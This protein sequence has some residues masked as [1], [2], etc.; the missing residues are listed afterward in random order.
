M[1]GIKPRPH[2]GAIGNIVAAV[3][4]SE[5]LDSLETGQHESEKKPDVITDTVLSVVRSATNEVLAPQF[6]AL[7]MFGYGVSLYQKKPFLV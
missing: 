3:N 5:R 2:D 7:L 6:R 4:S 1:M